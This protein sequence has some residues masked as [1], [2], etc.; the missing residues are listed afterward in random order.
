MIS[1]IGAVILAGCLMT[2]G[3][4]NQRLE[5]T[6][7][8][9][10]QE[11]L[12]MEGIS[13]DQ[14]NHSILTLYGDRVYITDEEIALMERCVMSEAGG[15]SCECQEAVATVILNRWQNP[16]KYPDTISG[17]INEEGQFSTHDNGKPTV[18]VRV[19]VHNAIIFYNTYQMQIPYQV[20]WFRA[21]NYHEDLGMP[22]IS[23]DNT[24]FS[25]DENAVVN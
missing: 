19:A 6:M 13:E 7:L 4:V 12:D 2:A 25:I 21:D 11:E 10:L 14:Y 20:Y 22:Y 8:T 1:T 17:V 23:I 3:R 15:C 5:D 16:D 24:Y 9:C 18:S